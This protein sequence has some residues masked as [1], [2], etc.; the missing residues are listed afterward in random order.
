[1]PLNRDRDRAWEASAGAVELKFAEPGRL[2]DA[3]RSVLAFMTIPRARGLH[4]RS[5]GTRVGLYLR[6][7]DVSP[8][9]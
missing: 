2:M 5:L 6:Q 4:V 1:M 9:T 8:C 7:R 3:Q